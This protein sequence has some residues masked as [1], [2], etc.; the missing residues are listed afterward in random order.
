[1]TRFR[2]VGVRLD[3][4]EDITLVIEANDEQDAR[5]IAKDLRIGVGK[6]E[7]TDT[8][9][10]TNFSDP[11][12]SRPMLITTGVTLALLTIAVF[13]WVMME[14]PSQNKGIQ[15]LTYPQTVEQPI[16]SK[17]NI[18]LQAAVKQCDIESIK[19]HIHY[20]T[21]LSPDDEGRSPQS[22]AAATCDEALQLLI[23]AGADVNRKDRDGMTPL[24][25]AAASGSLERTEL[26]LSAGAYVDKL[27]DA[28]RSA[29]VHAIKRD[30]F[31]FTDT[32]LK[33][34]ILLI[35]KGSNINLSVDHV[36]DMNFTQM[37]NNKTTQIIAKG[38]PNLKR[39]KAMKLFERYYATE[40]RDSWSPNLPN[41]VVYAMVDGPNPTMYA[42]DW[43]TTILAMAVETGSTQL[44]SHLIKKNAR[45]HSD[46]SGNSITFDPIYSAVACSNGEMLSQLLNAGAVVQCPIYA[47]VASPLALAVFQDDLQITKQLLEA[48]ANPNYGGVN[49][50]STPLRRAVENKSLGMVK[51]LIESGADLELGLNS[52]ELKPFS[53]NISPLFCAVMHRDLNITQLLL[54]AGA[55]PNAYNDP[56]GVFPRITP[57]HWAA[58]YLS[59]KD[60]AELIKLLLSY[61]ASVDLPQE[62]TLGRRQG[63]TPL[64]LADDLAMKRLLQSN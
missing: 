6:V 22:I 4:A 49:N 28:K 31:I 52:S 32:Q 14:I 1:M 27:D 43:N 9:V 46:L 54:E 63:K 47:L 41:N 48:G 50:C 62:R 35:D 16:F 44:T 57:L 15:Q 7:A 8:T 39:T 11:F 37:K 26:L 55:N 36:H 61:G 53:Y 30:Q 3:N 13:A 33:I 21:M 45:I 20:K 60:D 2:I 34:S 56:Q 64:E 51:L 10:E 59:A 5:Q 23:E 18:S 25:H 12:L 19:A 42:Q 40:W 58:E 38:F 17:P 24:M 29:L